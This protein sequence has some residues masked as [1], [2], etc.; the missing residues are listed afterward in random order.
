MKRYPLSNI[1][2]LFGV[3]LVLCAADGIWLAKVPNKDRQK[4]NPYHAQPDAIA[5]GRNLFLDHC[6]Y[7][8]G[9]KAEGRGKKPS[10]RSF[11]V[12]QGAS[13]GELHWLL[14]NGNL[15]RGMPSWSKLPDAQRWQLVVYIKSLGMAEPAR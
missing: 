15:G 11:T 6:A 7:C 12:Q 4:Q 5:A 8:H 13:E 3:S 2:L 14:V 9:E 1:V 10:L